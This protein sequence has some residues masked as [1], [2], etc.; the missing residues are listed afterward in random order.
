MQ[1]ITKHTRLSTSENVD[2]PSFYAIIPAN[3]R[4]CKELEPN[5]K[6]LYGEITALCNKE[7]YCW[8]SNQYFAELYEVDERTVRRWI[9][10]LSTNTFIEV[11]HSDNQFCQERKIFITD[12]F[13][14]SSTA[15]KI[16]RPPALESPD[17]NVRHNKTRENNTY[18]KEKIYKKDKAPAAP[19]KTSY[20][21]HVSL[22]EEQH[23]KLL[24]LYGKEK[25]EQ[26]FDKLD[27]FKGASG[28]K[29]ES[30]YHTMVK[31]GWVHDE[32][33][34]KKESK[35]SKSSGGDIEENRKIAM[36]AEKAWKSQ[37]YT[38]EVLSKGV[39]IIPKGPGTT[40][41]INYSEL[42]FKEQLESALRKNHFTKPL[43]KTK[44]EDI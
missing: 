8:A 38:L 30:D 7:G 14:K 13:K 23:G 17:K 6:L 5:A 12:Q 1:N 41:V 16:V 20:R 32:F 37:H 28:R 40:T 42:G 3:V 21:D 24:A 33:F 29:Y 34:V 4:Y 31:G 39:E 18:K 15:D 44:E 25:L 27:S 2:K 22:T 35:F 11:V 10:S 19:E 43:P 9:E 36:E 26:A